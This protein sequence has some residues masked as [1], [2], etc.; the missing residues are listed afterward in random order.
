MKRYNTMLL[1]LLICFG[2]VTPLSG[3]GEMDNTLLYK[4]THR[5]SAGT[6]VTYTEYS[7]VAQEKDGYWLQRLV[8]MSPSAE[9]VSIT[10]TL[11]GDFS[12]EPLRY[13]MHRPAKM[14]T[15]ANVID[16]PLEK[17]GKDEVLPT[18]LTGK[19]Q[20]IEQ[21]QIEA[22]TFETKKGREGDATF[23]LSLDI[24]VMGVAQVETPEWTM[25]L[26]SIEDGTVDLLPKKPPK[27]GIVYLDE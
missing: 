13:I 27:G 3:L 16:L 14:N 23:W 10:Q 22:G 25:E 18:P 21:I 24:P 9:P 11:M 26:V 4:V 1:I 8:K 17:M 12:H 2:A 5:T 6:L 20:E 7:I 15:P 19:F